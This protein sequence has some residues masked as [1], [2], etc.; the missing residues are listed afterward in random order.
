MSLNVIKRGPQIWILFVILGLLISPLFEV[1]AYI[2]EILNLHECRASSRRNL[3]QNLA[4][5]FSP[6]KISIH[7]SVMRTVNVNYL[8]LLVSYDI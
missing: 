4:N 1:V 7:I 6:E 5:S 8:H 2:W 3:Q